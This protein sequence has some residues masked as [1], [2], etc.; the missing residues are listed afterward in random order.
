MK[1]KKMMTSILAG[2][3][4]M[5]TLTGC[6][7]AQ[8]AQAA[9]H[10]TGSNAQ[11]S[12]VEINFLN[13]YTNGNH[14]LDTLIEQFNTSQTEIKVNPLFVEGSS[15]SKLMEEYQN[16]AATGKAPEVTLSG[17]TYLDYMSKNMPI[18]P[19]SDFIEEEKFDTNDFY[20]TMLELGKDFDGK[21]WML[22]TVIST[23]IV[24]YNKKLFTNAGL[25]PENPPQT[26]EEVRAAAKKIADTGAQ[27]IY[28]GAITDTESWVYQGILE[29]MGGRMLSDDRKSAA[30]NSQ[31]GVNA[32]SFVNDLVNT[33][34][35]M[36]N[37]DMMQAMQHFTQ[38]EIGIYISSTALLAS[39]VSN[40]DIAVAKFPSDQTHDIRVP[41]G[42]NCVAISESTPEKE[43][44]AWT[45]VKFLTSPE[46]S[47][48]FSKGTGYMATRK[49]AV[50]DP[51]LL[52][53]Y[54]KSEPRAN[55]TYEQI[56]NLVSWQNYPGKGGTKIPTI[57]QDKL[58]SI[59]NGS[60]TPQEGLDAAAKEVNELLN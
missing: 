20:P 29:T 14:V 11:G 31:E 3:L 34:K 16:Y 38:G 58:Q 59:L 15:Y 18:V 48:A 28:V 10:Q 54:L 56:P 19:I 46:V 40:P 36:T 51:K 23:P 9:T 49:S 52:G 6:E 21:Q 5:S 47:A 53:D 41:A 43:A 8:N 12:P 4:I 57:I 26:F 27:G 42:G 50:E 30:F 7:T 55:I 39:V 24:Y 32:I 60:T 33:D 22:P 1:M 25:D 45:F 37:Q 13:I 2:L 17:L 35:S 44:A